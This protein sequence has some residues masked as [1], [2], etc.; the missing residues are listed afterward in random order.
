MEKLFEERSKAYYRST[1]HQKHQRLCLVGLAI[2]KVMKIK[3]GS[4]QSVF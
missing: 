1:E 2:D 3:T 4:R